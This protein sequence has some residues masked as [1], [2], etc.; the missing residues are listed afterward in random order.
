MSE[1]LFNNTDQ[2]IDFSRVAA[3]LPT[4]V[5]ELMKNVNKRNYST[6]MDGPSGRLGIGT[7]NPKP[8]EVVARVS[9]IKAPESNQNLI[10]GIDSGLFISLLAG[11]AAM[12]GAYLGAKV[13]MQNLGNT[14]KNSGRT[15]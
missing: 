3:E 5:K 12:G 7:Q 8:P 2:V 14:G 1:K 15:S 4:Q 6:A 13:K 11:L 9:E 10:L